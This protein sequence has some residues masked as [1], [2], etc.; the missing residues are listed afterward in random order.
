MTSPR[1]HAHFRLLVTLAVAGVVVA[2]GGAPATAVPTGSPSAPGPDAGPVAT[3]LDGTATEPDVTGVVPT[4]VASPTQAAGPDAAAAEDVPTEAPS[5]TD[6]TSPAP[7]PTEDVPTDE[8][9]P[10]DA[11]GTP[12]PQPPRII[13]WGPESGPT[14]G[15]T[16]IDFFMDGYSPERATMEM[17][18]TRLTPTGP[19]RLLI[20]HGI[21][22]FVT[23]P[24]APGEA[25]ITFT[26]AGGTQSRT[27]LYVGPA[28]GVGASGDGGEPGTTA[29]RLATTGGSGPSALVAAL[30]L[31]TLGAGMVETARR[32]RARAS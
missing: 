8:P 7:T 18:G 12:A 23:P 9:S 13:G 26:N 29:A 14:A 22:T 11:P 31:L 1:P 10:T 19:P 2:A 4:D 16:F 30:A 3:P 27:F 25:T 17:C 28:G 15:G 20:G 6:V 32:A 21:W 5:P 24:C